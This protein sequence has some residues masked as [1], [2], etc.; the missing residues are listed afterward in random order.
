MSIRYGKFV[1]VCNVTM[2][3]YIFNVH[4]IQYVIF[5]KSCINK[6]KFEYCSS[7]HFIAFQ[8]FSLPELHFL[9]QQDLNNDV[10]KT[11]H[12]HKYIGSWRLHNCSFF[13]SF[14]NIQNKPRL[15]QYNH[16]KER[17][18]IFSFVFIS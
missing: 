14:C 1:C 17:K 8:N 6:M 5:N 15:N 18:S 2:S 7:F 12:I 11:L 9:S 13:L 10:L 16:F 3:N 4:V